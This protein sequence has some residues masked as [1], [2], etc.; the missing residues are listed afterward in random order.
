MAE[1][2]KYPAAQGN[3]ETA[4]FWE[5]A[6]AGKF[7]IKRCTACGEPHYFRRLSR[8]YFSDWLTASRIFFRRLSRIFSRLAA[9]SAAY[10][11][12]CKLIHV[13]RLLMNRTFHVNWF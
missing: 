1:A 8:I 12:R 5:A 11:Y 4:P 2:K 13:I 10:R 3:P 9:N 7:L 6:K